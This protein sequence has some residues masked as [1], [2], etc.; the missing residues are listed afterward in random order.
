MYHYILLDLIFSIYRYTNIRYTY[1]HEI[2]TCLISIIKEE[3]IKHNHVCIKGLCKIRVFKRYN[4]KSKT[5]TK[6]I[7][8]KFD[9]NFVKKMNFLL[10]NK[11]LY[12]KCN[13]NDTENR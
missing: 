8:T 1:V 9:K 12:Y 10:K 4:S 13:L 2:I 3:L 7:I 11:E 5:Y 6:Y